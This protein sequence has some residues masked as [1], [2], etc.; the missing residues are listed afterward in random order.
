MD[1]KHK[2]IAVIGLGYVG[3]PLAA[4]FGKHRDVI[5][6]DNSF[7]RI[8]EL[9]QGIDNTREL[10]IEELN[11]SN[12]LTFTSDV[13][14]IQSCEIFIVTVPTPIDSGNHPNL[15]PLVVASE[16][17]GKV[18]KIGAIVIFESTV[19]PGCTE[20]ICVPILEKHS[21]L[22]FNETFFCGYSPERINPGD[23]A[24]RLTDIKKITSGS[25]KEVSEAIDELYKEIIAAGTFK[26]SSI[27]VA[28]AAKIIENV[29]RDVNIALVN[30]LSYIF[31]TLKLDTYEILN[32]ANSKWNFLPFKPGLVGGHCIGVDPYYLIHKSQEVGYYPELISAGRRV[33]NSMAKHIA[34][35]TIKRILSAE[36]SILNAK[37]LILGLTFKEN[38]PDI[39]NT[40]VVD[41]YNAFKEYCMDVD[42]YDPLVNTSEVK[43]ILNIPCLNSL[44]EFGNYS[45]IIIAVGH[46]EFKNMGLARIKELGVS[47]A[48]INDF[49]NIFS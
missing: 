23:N 31:D 7:K 46:D 8:D 26:A 29:Q 13:S 15:E 36:K 12:Y 2:K 41:L 3:L 39:R 28:E 20:D 5:G 21:G 33:N 34:D 42:I 40:K 6:Y 37:V 38:C 25:T 17:I 45:A 1:I 18:M 47:D 9:K 49:K 11:K 32:A 14:D 19:F 10:S 4:A 35:I 16:M 43:H 24:R 44:P 27:K 30:E 48:Y 22:I